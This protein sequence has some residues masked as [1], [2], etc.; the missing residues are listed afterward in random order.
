MN[1]YEFKKPIGQKRKSRVGRGISAG[2]GKTAGRGTKGQKSRSGYNLPKRFEGGQTPLISRLPKA[3]GKKSI[4]KKIGRKTI[5]VSLETIQKNF[6]AG[7]T[8]DIKNL[9]GKNIIKKPGSLQAKIKIIGKAN[10]EVKFKF[11]KNIIFAKSSKPT[12]EKK[13]RV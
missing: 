8:I 12:E 9:V 13:S 10:K 6:K 2:Q 5:G 1:L 11:G 7:E 3:R 4:N